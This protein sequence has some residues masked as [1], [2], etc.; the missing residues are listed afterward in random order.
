MN[1]LVIGSGGR[2]HALVWKIAQSKNVTKI[3]CA[4]GNGGICSVADCIPIKPDD[5]RALSEF[6]LNNKIDLTVVGPEQP[7]TLG[8]VDVFTKNGLKIFGPSAKAAEIEGSKVFAKTLMKKYGIPTAA[9]EV[10]TEA[11]PAK[12]FISEM[13]RACVVKA[14]GL[15]G[16]KGAIVCKTSY[17]ALTAVDTIRDEF[18]G[19]GNS[20]VIEEFMDGEEASLFAVTDGKN[21]VILPAAQ[22]HKRIFDG[23]KGKN[24]GG[25]GAYAP[26]PVVTSVVLER[27]KKEII[28]PAI[29]ALASEDRPYKGVLYCG[30]MLTKTGPKVVE[31]NCRFGD[32]ECQAVLPLIKSDMVD[33]FLSVTDG[34]IGSYQ[35]EV[36]NQ[37][38]VC[39]VMAS[40]GYPDH[41]EKYKEISG[42]DSAAAANTFIFHAGT[43]QK[44]GK[45]YSAG[46]RVL[47]ITSV[48]DQLSTAVKQAYS[49]VK[50]IHFEKAHFRKDIG[51]RALGSNEYGSVS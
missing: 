43:E 23:D 9:F 7:L 11:A 26:A 40:G 1:I 20:I 12:K 44:N 5:T 35:L 39:I 50:K 4:N 25:M 38:A 45:T 49:A 3:Y 10:F 48:A 15:A 41:Y 13:N 32:P 22:D 27:V 46:G 33:L 31:F 18:G 37:S 42:L 24:T 6:A 21:Y 51:Y 36:Y 19:A 29:L 34:K 47:G 28:E 8:I 17:E 14:D 2:E 30:L 16:G